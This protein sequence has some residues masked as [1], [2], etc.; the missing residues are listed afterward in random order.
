MCSE[1]HLEISIDPV[2]CVGKDVAIVRYKH[3]SQK[4]LH[5]DQDRDHDTAF[6]PV[7]NARNQLRNQ[8]SLA[9][10]RRRCDKYTRRFLCVP[11]TALGVHELHPIEEAFHIAC[12]RQDFW[13]RCISCLN[14]HAQFEHIEVPPREGINDSSMLSTKGAQIALM[15]YIH[16]VA[17]KEL[18]S[19]IPWM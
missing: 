1:D 14:W 9:C 7:D 4:L 17:R 6:A 19:M 2:P 12:L 11:A 8:A 10:C 15:K 18:R 13:C 16:D 5:F 3:H